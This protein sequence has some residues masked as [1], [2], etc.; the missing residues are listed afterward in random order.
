MMFI[1]WTL[2]RMRYDQVMFLGWQS[3]IPLSLAV[4]VMTAVMVFNGLT[5]WWELLGANVAL[6]A[7]L[8]L[9]QPLLPKQQVNRKLKLYGS[10]FSPVDGEVVSHAAPAGMSREDR[11]YESTVPV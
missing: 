4:V 10:R 8:L 2:P 5:A 1:R 11:P 9:I 7:V 3:M 6:A